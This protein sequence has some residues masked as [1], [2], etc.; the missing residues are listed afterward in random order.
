ME[1][2]HFALAQ[3]VSRLCTKIAADAVTAPS[4]WNPRSKDERSMRASSGTQ[5]PKRCRERGTPIAAMIENS[6]FH[7][8]PFPYHV[9]AGRHSKENQ[10]CTPENT[11]LKRAIKPSANE[12]SEQRRT[13]D[14]P[15]EPAHHSERP[16]Q[17]PFAGALPVLAPLPHSRDGTLELAIF[18]IRRTAAGCFIAHN[19]RTSES[20]RRSAG[21]K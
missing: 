20:C 11:G 14:S 7:T 8:H 12:C 16:S 19:L 17:R 1:L 13:Y 21:R 18:P 2:R 9:K 15:A 5:H 4:E 6:W 3:P 10:S